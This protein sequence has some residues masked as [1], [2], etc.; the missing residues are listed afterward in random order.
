MDQK[1][2]QTTPISYVFTDDGGP[3]VVFEAGCDTGPNAGLNSWKYVFKDVAEHTAAMAYTRSKKVNTGD[4]RTGYDAANT[5]K[6]LLE[7]IEAPKPYVLVGHSLGG[8]YVLCFAKLFPEDVA[9]LV[10]VD[11][12]LKGMNQEFQRLKMFSDLTKYPANIA[13]EMKGIKETDERQAPM[14]AELGELP[15]TLIAA[16]KR[17]GHPI[18]D[19][20]FPILKKFA[21]ELQNCRYVEAHGASHYVQLDAP[22]I[23]LKEIR[24]I[25]AKTKR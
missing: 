2:G 10:L 18:E 9:G 19:A 15:I 25:V 23:V 7:E 12:T 6:R 4:S 13:A 20:A 14:P 3:T 21:E 16:T 11:P 1:R 22:E 8:M 17:S 24:L 5:L